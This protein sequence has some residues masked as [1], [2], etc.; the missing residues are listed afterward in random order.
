MTTTYD[1]LQLI[2]PTPAQLAFE[3]AI[4]EIYGIEGA[5]DLLADNE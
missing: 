1:E 5:A 4:N 3:E 2:S